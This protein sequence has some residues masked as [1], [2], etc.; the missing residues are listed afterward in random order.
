MK[1]SLIFAPDNPTERSFAPF[2]SVAFIE[3]LRAQ[4]MQA[5]M[6]NV[7]PEGGFSTD[8]LRGTEAD[9]V[10]TFGPVGW[11]STAW[12]R[13]AQCGCPVIHFI[14]SEFTGPISASDRKVGPKTWSPDDHRAKHASRLVSAIIGSNRASIRRWIDAGFFSC[15]TFSVVAAPPLSIAGS[16]EGARPAAPSD[17]SI[18]G[19]YDQLGAPAPL[20]LL[21]EALNLAG[22]WHLFRVMVALAG[23]RR[24]TIVRAPPNVNFCAAT[25]IANFIRLIDVLVVLCEDE[26]AIE[27]AL[28]AVGQSKI[29]V[30]PDG[31]TIAEMIGH[32]RHRLLYEA[33]SPYALAAA[34]RL[35]TQRRDDRG[36]DLK[37]ADEA[38]FLCG[39][40]S[41]AR[42]FAR[43]YSRLMASTLS[44][45]PGGQVA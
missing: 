31:S 39:P 11:L 12:M 29:V 4:G 33:G 34:L 17:L 27:A 19:C 9:V 22:D 6:V 8:L 36:V 20:R 32:G 30:V 14:G 37:T 35:A 10:H 24:R 44:Q 15:A 5:K 28:T 23:M 7:T 16:V 25:S 40:E 45:A 26:S 38:V 1:I 42:T 43:A 18:M 3:A 21:F 41:V 2:K 13:A